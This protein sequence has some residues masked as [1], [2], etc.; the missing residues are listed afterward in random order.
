MS[1]SFVYKF[2]YFLFLLRFSSTYVN[3]DYRNLALRSGK[4]VIK[5][6]CIPALPLTQTTELKSIPCSNDCAIISCAQATYPIAPVGFDPPTGITYGVLP[7]HS[8]RSL[9]FASLP[10]DLLRSVQQLRFQHLISGI[11]N[12]YR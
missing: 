12:S 1:G 9:L 11:R 6:A 2:C 5:P 10:S 3:S 4:P 8:L 7:F